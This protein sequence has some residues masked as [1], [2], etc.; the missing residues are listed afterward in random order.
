MIVITFSWTTLTHTSQLVQK[1]I[2]FRRKANPIGLCYQSAN[3]YNLYDT[4]LQ[5]SA[6]MYCMP[7]KT[8]AFLCHD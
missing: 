3:V 8:R 1:E 4:L 5:I 2:K 6:F 7:I